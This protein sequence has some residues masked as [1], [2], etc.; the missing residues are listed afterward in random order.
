MAIHKKHPRN[1]K[2]MC[3]INY[4]DIKDLGQFV[5]DQL[6][7]HWRR[8]TCKNC[9]NKEPKRL[10]LKSANL[11]LD[12]AIKQLKKGKSPDSWLFQFCLQFKRYCKL[13]INAN[14]SKPPI[15]NKR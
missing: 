14:T 12:G 3:N 8:V 10:A 13:D 4:D 6:A 15:K 7:G 1:R 5:Q 2:T 9:L 11:C